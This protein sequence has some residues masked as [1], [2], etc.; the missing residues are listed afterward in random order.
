VL[1]HKYVKENKFVDALKKEALMSM[2]MKNN[3]IGLC[4]LRICN[5]RKRTSHRFKKYE[6]P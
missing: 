1:K 5:F 2:S 6:K 4:R 3:T